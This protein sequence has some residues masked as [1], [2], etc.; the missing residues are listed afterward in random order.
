MR[1]NYDIS[2]FGDDPLPENVH[3]SASGSM[4]E[5][6]INRLPHAGPIFRD[7]NKTVFVMIT[8]AVSGPSVDSTIKFYSRR[9]YGRAAFIALIANHSG[10]TKYQAIVKSRSK[11]FQNIKWNGRNYPL[12][13]HVSNHRTAIDGL[14]YFAT[15]IGNDVP[16]T[17]QRVEFLL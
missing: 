16:N 1:D 6:L 17:P 12:E 2:N 11:K 7:E 5:E 14:R 8:K 9:K 13:N 15:H 10:D 4:L 3:C